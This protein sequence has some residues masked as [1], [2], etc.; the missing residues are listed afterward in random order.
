M[1]RRRAFRL[2]KQ[3]SIP[4]PRALPDFAYEAPEPTMECST[5]LSYAGTVWTRAL[6]PLKPCSPQKGFRIDRA[7]LD[8]AGV[9][10][11]GQRRGTEAPIP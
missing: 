10:Q 4:R 2:P 6:E 5:R 1:S 7:G 9:A 8:C 11:H 3:V